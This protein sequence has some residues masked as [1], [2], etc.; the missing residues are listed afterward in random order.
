K[1]RLG[2]IELLQEA[3]SKALG[4]RIFRDRRTALTYTSDFTPD[5]IA[6]FVRDSVELASLAEPDEL[7]RL[8]DREDLATSQPDLELYNERVL[9]IDAKQAIE[10][11]REGEAA[12]RSYSDKI[13]NSD[14]AS[15]SRTVGASAFASSDG[16]RGGYRGSYQSLTVEP[17]ADDDGGKKRNGYWW[18]GNRFLD[19]LESPESVGREASRR[20]L[21]K[22]GADKIE[23]GDLPIVFDPDAGRGILGLLLGVISG[24]AI[25]R[26]S[27]YLLEREGTQVASSLVHLSDDPLIKRA[28]GSR[29]YDGD[30]L[31]SRKNHVVDGGILKTYLFDV[32]SARKL[33]RRSNGCAGRGVGG[34]PHVSSSN[35]IMER[36][37][38]PRAQVV[39]DVKRGLY[40]TSM[41]GFGFNAVTGDFSRG[42]EGFLIEDGKLGRPVGEITIS[43]NL[44]DILK[45]IEAVGDDLDMRS[46]TVCPT[47]RVSRM[48]VAGR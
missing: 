2:E 22:V 38:T 47:F 26:K 15:Y 7:N 23:T 18:T 42:A 27:S 21:A 45:R 36:G 20:T 29:P 25:Y 13:T 5:G 28:P 3:S 6:R 4:L 19:K 31:P 33:G 40:V 48:T 41:M 16:F 32:Y 11:C 39:G 46:S 30:G 24:G 34:A 9:S 12:S 17:I 35:F 8:P 10:R 43:A 37:T 1:V 14:G 44:D